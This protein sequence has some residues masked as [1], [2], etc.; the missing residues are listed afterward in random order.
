MKI[1]TESVSAKFSAAV[2]SLSDKIQKISSVRISKKFI[3]IGFVA[4]ILVMALSSAVILIDENKADTDISTTDSREIDPAV[5]G[6]SAVTPVEGSFIFALTN[7]EK[8]NVLSVVKIDFSSDD[9]KVVYEFIPTA[10]QV[11]LNGTVSDLS[12]HLASGGT[13]L[14]LTALREYTGTEFL[15]YVVGDENSL[16]HLFQLLGNTET[17]IE[18]RVSHDHNGVDFIIEEGTQTL[19]PDMMLKYYLY[20]INDSQS[21]AEKIIGIIIDCLE[22]LVDSVDDTELESDFCK[23]IGYFDTDVSAFDYSG[24]K[25]LLKAIPGMNLK[26]KSQP[27]TE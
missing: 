19:T 12:G 15:R 13:N 24:N 21:N 3:I 27:V 17:E 4:V 9:E 1:S 18:S 8:T 10:T 20:L 26:E 25:E 6:S 14:L 5:F 23:A 11:N 16:L 22:R 7:N 2:S